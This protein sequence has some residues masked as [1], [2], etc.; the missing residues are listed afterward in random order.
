MSRAPFGRADRV[1]ALLRREVA[2]LVHEDVKNR[3][4]PEMSVSDV[5]VSRDL[6]QA[7]VYVTALHPEESTLGVKLLNENG[8]GYR[9]KLSKLLEMRSVPAIRFR[10][11][12]SVD[13]GERI[14]ELLKNLNTPS[15]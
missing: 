1:S 15:T 14:E 12:E 4:V 11:D 6:A 7:T 3:L 9:H 13:R 2:T 5:E 10:Y 8:R